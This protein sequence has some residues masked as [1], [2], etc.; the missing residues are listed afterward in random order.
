MAVGPA[1]KGS[2]VGSGEK[3]NPPTPNPASRGRVTGEVVTGPRPTGAVGVGAAGTGL[4]SP[5]D[6]A[7]A[8]ALGEKSSPKS[9]E[10]KKLSETQVLSEIRRSRDCWLS[11]WKAS[12]NPRK[13]D[14]KE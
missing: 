5:T 1:S 4:G 14:R 9:V 7:M 10:L 2:E 13:E 11:P 3:G 12:G 8:T 6:A